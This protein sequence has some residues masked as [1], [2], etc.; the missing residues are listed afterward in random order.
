MIAVLYAV[1]QVV[2]EV[3]Y[4]DLW[5]RV[6]TEYLRSLAQVLVLSCL[7]LDLGSSVHYYLSCPLEEHLRA[8]VWIH[9][10]MVFGGV[11]IP[12]ISYGR[13]R[14]ANECD[15]RDTAVEL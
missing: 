5:V 2:C 8:F 9:D 4:D 3:A 13:E 15:S 12:P 11:A 6:V 10:G 1:G 7:S 14:I